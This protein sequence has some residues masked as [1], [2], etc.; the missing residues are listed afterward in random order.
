V[1]SSSSSLRSK[2]M[3]AQILDMKVDVD[4]TGDSEPSI[5]DQLLE[6]ELALAD[7]KIGTE[8]SSMRQP[9]QEG[10]ESSIRNELSS[11]D[12]A[13]DSV[14]QWREARAQSLAKA[15]DDKY[16]GQDD[17]NDAID[18]FV[19]QVCEAVPESS[20]EA[21]STQLGASDGDQYIS[22]TTSDIWTKQQ[23][24][25]IEQQMLKSDEAIASLR[26]A[27]AKTTADVAADSKAVPG[28]YL[29]EVCPEKVSVSILF[30]WQEQPNN[31][32]H[33]NLQMYSPFL[34]RLKNILK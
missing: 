4:G 31:P 30:E 12:S 8:D 32:L 21:L 27:L 25:S 1:T 16:Y 14:R 9:L 28:K 23:F 26:S 20:L 24:K 15:M 22:S 13:I 29:Q 18:E 10:Y 17:E 2:L 6:S 11:M 3:S 5:S 19:S 33:R 34:W 7:S